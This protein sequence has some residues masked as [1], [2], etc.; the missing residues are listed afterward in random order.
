MIHKGE[1]IMRKANMVLWTVML[2]ITLSSCSA[3]MGSRG[4]VNN[5]VSLSVVYESVEVMCYKDGGYPYLHDVFT[6]RSGKTILYT[7]RAMLAYDKNGE[8]LRIQWHPMD[9][10][11]TK[12]Y[13]CI[14]NDEM[15]LSDQETKDVPGGWSL[16]VSERGDD[17]RTAYDVA[18]A[19]YC[20]KSITF[21]DGT[22]WKNPEYK[23]WRADY[24][25]K[26][27]DVSELKAFYPYVQEIK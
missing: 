2:C 19:L 3:T 18:Y 10:S 17:T 16:A 24:R 13:E 15:N 22:I 9:S 23:K 27:V 25:G 20:N 4:M 8:P 11:D 5:E 21:D 7:E 12:E 6:N 1:K 26:P 14:Y